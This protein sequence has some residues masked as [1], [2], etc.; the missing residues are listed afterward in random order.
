MRNLGTT[1]F[2]RNVISPNCCFIET[3]FYR[4]SQKKNITGRNLTGSLHSRIVE[5]PKLHIVEWHFSES[6]FSRTWFSRNYMQPNVIS[7]NT[8][9]SY[10]YLPCYLKD[11]KSYS[12]ITVTIIITFYWMVVFRSM[13][14]RESDVRLNDDSEKC[15]SAKRRFERNTFGKMTIRE[16]DFRLNDISRDWHSAKY[17]FEKMIFDII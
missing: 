7:P 6:L 13:H 9:W 2:S 16:N 1:S 5:L 14:F 3:S 15:H 10:E 4:I 12:S 17:L 8:M 11:H